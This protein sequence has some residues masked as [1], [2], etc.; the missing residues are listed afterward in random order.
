MIELIA[1]VAGLLGYNV[2]DLSDAV[3]EVQERRRE[4]RIQKRHEREA[5]YVSN[6]ILFV[7]FDKYYGL[8]N[9][10]NG[11]QKYSALVDGKVIDTTIFTN[12]GNLSI[13]RNPAELLFRLI[14]SNQIFN[15]TENI[16]ES[17][18]NYAPK[19]LERVERMGYKLWD[20][21]QYRLIDHNRDDGKHEFAFSESNFYSYRFASS[22]LLVDEL[23]DALIEKSGNVDNVLANASKL[24]PIRNEL[25]PN[26]NSFT[27][28]QSRI[29][30]GGIGVVFA[31][32][33]GNPHNDY[34]IPIQ[35]RSQKVN[36][37]RG[38]FAVIP[39]AFHEPLVGHDDEVNIYWTIFRELYEE[40]FGGDEVEADS[41][42]VKHDWY[43]DTTP[44]VNYFR[45]HEGAFNLELIGYGVNAIAGNYEF[46]VLLAVRD[47]WYWNTFGNDITKNWEALGI[48]LYSTKNAEKLKNLLTDDNWVNESI[49]K[50]IEGLI[51]L[52]EI[53]PSKVNLPFMER[54]L[55]E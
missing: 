14:S 19:A 43:F 51:R 49:F 28:Y 5:A 44:G 4:Q 20:S 52:Q 15:P 35:I 29:C 1:S 42:R 2:K 37:G 33:R 3:K 40:L 23:F 16:S 17:I 55:G 45:D 53:D 50:F 12:I 13:N 48:K 54:I 11:I 34:I 30:C 25:M 38:Q 26:I 8:Q 10:D 6:E 31:L 36:D 24:L 21:P 22:G 7:F 39:K 46:A 9:V 47:T 27:D 41:G 18:K 32:A